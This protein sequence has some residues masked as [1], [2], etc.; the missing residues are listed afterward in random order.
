MRK[1][2][3]D[4]QLADFH[5]SS[6]Q[7]VFSVVKTNPYEGN[8]ISYVNLRVE[9]SDE[10]KTDRIVL[11]FKNNKWVVVDVNAVDQ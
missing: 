4:F 5:Y 10:S 2:L 7:Y 3:A 1:Q 6:D 11:Q 9:G 8:V